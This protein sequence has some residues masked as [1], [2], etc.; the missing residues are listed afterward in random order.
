ML[1]ECRL[2]DGRW[3]GVHAGAPRGYDTGLYSSAEFEAD[4]TK[5]NA[6]TFS[7]PPG[8]PKRPPSAVR[9]GRARPRRRP[10]VY[11]STDHYLLGVALQRWLR[12]QTGSEADIHQD[13]LL[14]DLLGPAQPGPLLAYTQRTADQAAQP[15]VAYGL[16]YQADDMARLGLYLQRSDAMQQLLGPYDYD[17]IMFRSGPPGN[18]WQKRAVK[19]MQRASGALTLPLMRAATSLRGYPS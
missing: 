9:P 18:R 13:I 5:E 16:L 8:M 15:F 2:P 6:A 11:H 14:A 10:A 1:P 7:L 12:S 3:E 4:E 17:R 19:L